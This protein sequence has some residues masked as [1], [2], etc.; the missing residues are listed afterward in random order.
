MQL[1]K[2]FDPIV[3]RFPILIIY[4]VQSIYKPPATAIQTLAQNDKRVNQLIKCSFFSCESC[5]ERGI[6]WKKK[7]KML[8]KFPKFPVRIAAAGVFLVNFL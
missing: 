3:L 2:G 8:P 7:Y 4:V 1:Q 6:N 5:I